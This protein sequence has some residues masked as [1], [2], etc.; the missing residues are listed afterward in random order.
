VKFSA[1]ISPPGDFE[2]LLEDLEAQYENVLIENGFNDILE[3][4]RAIAIP[5]NEWVP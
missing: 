2:Q 3:L 5:C 1:E 4:F